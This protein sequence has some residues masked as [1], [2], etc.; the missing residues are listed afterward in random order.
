MNRKTF[1]LGGGSARAATRRAA[2]ALLDAL[3]ERACAAPSTDR[4]AERRTRAHGVEDG[5]SVLRVE[6]PR[7]AAEPVLRLL[8]MLGSG[9]EVSIQLLDEEVTTQEAAALLNVS[10]PHVIKLLDEEKIPHRL[11]GSHR[12]VRVED[13]LD[14]GEAM[15]RGGKKA[16]DELAS[17]AQAREMGYE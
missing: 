15:R 7:A 8:E 5:S 9:K 13:I 4:V 1:H 12:R 3:S 14:Y 16:L 17:E 6:V 11:V 2:R 10:R